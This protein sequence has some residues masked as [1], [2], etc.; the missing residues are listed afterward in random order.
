MD[1]RL[2]QMKAK[3]QALSHEYLVDVLEYDPEVGLF[4]WKKPVAHCIKPGMIAGTLNKNVYLFIKVGKYIYRAHR[5]AWFYFY[6]EWPPMNSYQIDHIGGNR[7]NNSIHN[8]RLVTNAKN[9]KNHGLYKNN[10]SGVSGVSFC[11]LKGK[12][13]ASMVL[14]Q[15]RIHLGYFDFFEDAVKARKQAEK[16]YGFICRE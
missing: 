16:E 3:E 7:L 5:L 4:I 11:T 8:L 13:K 1:K 12:W 2:E 6:G 14:N 10:T 15:K 9:A